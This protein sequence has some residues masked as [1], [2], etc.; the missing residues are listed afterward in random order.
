M[1][2]NASGQGKVVI[3]LVVVIVVLLG[4]IVGIVVLGKSKTPSTTPSAETPATPTGGMPPA[5]T[6]EFDPAT[7]TK[8]ASG[9]TPE[10]HV[11][12]Y[13]EAVLKGDYAK[14]YDLLPADKK[15]AQDEA[16]FAEQLKGYGITAY[17]IDDVSQTDTEAKVTATA[18]MAGGSFQYL[19]TFVKDGGT[20][21]VKSRTLP[22]MA[23]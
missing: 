11:K 13:F 4:A 9:V 8:V 16:S 12:D 1:S 20:W 2:E 21:V 15:V 14:A 19:W 3:A 10:Q 18:T 7:A 23:Q 17:T 6:G 22:G 5:T